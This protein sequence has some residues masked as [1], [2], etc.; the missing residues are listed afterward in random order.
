MT[1]HDSSQAVTG[2]I[3]SGPSDNY[4]APCDDSNTARE[5][6]F[7]GTRKN[8]KEKKYLA[9]GKKAINSASYKLL[10]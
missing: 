1:N 4:V 2:V 3:I 10:P 8:K 6:S 7:E 5:S 9:I